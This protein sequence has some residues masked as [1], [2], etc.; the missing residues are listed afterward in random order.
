VAGVRAPN[1]PEAKRSGLRVD[2][3]RLERDGDGWLTPEERYAL[4]T[5]GVCAQVQPGVFMVRC[6]VPGGRLTPD[7][8]RSVADLADDHGHGWIHVS[9]RQ[10]LELH[11]V[12]AR[13]V[14]EVLR[15]CDAIGLTNRST[16]G[17][18]MRNVMS[19]PDA[20]VGLDEPF[21]CY[22]DAQMVSDAIVARSAELNC[23]LP[24]RINIAFGG[25]PTC[26]DHARLNDG[27]FVS[28][29]SDGVPGYQL[30]AAG[31]LGTKPYLALLLADFVP[32]EHVVAA[33]RALIDVFVTHGDIDD[34]KRG[35]MKFAV[36]RLG[37]AAF[38][39]AFEDTFAEHVAHPDYVST[40]PELAVIGARR[41][42]EILRHVP[43]GGWGSGV[44]P[45]RT[46]GRATV[47][48]NV[49]LGDLTSLETRCLAAL[50]D[51]HGEGTLHLTRNQNVAL[52]AV[53]LAHLPAV[54]AALAVHGLGLQGA[55]D[56]TDVR[57][58]TGSA[59]C[60][61]GITAA[62]DAGRDLLAQPGLVRNSGLRLHISGC[63]NACAQHQAADI[64]LSGAK[65][66]INGRIR[67]GYHLWLGADIAQGRIASMLG[68]VADTDVEAVV[69]AVIG[70]W[71]ATRRRG[72][73]FA[74]TVNRLGED[75]F[76]AQIAGI[77]D[78]FN[79]GGDPIPDDT[80]EGTLAVESRMLEPQV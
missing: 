34:P 23:R 57:A 63:P 38:R 52:R 5:Y 19:C 62:P 65:V 41:R 46:P 70:V 12:A 22:P 68:R 1:I 18:T 60:S 8:A 43:D 61:L 50:A 71:E 11:W 28:L 69:D 20:G 64:G 74:A 26:R 48:V 29:L 78:G 25:C 73:T 53:P 4:K 9:T 35:R 17:H 51:A 21:D 37:E 56:A 7:Q 10:N 76:A 13:Q 72:E 47:T 59:V 36:E 80:A 79:P 77:A 31:S 66:K 54:R 45:E 27:G 75:A 44:R 39:D 15:R 3:G 40:V 32:R 42:A 58:C 16:C 33:A 49:P 30:W 55:D 14:P 2:L 24:S 6:R 67:L